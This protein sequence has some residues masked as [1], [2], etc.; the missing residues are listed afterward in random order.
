VCLLQIYYGYSKDFAA[1]YQEMLEA[2]K[3]KREKQKGM[4]SDIQC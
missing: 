1:Q 3:R 2:E 4:T